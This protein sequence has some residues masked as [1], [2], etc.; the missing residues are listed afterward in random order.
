MPDASRPL[1]RLAL[2]DRV[3][4]AALGDLVF[5]RESKRRWLRDLL[6]RLRRGSRVFLDRFLLAQTVTVPGLFLVGL[7]M[8][9]YF[10]FWSWFCGLLRPSPCAPR[11]NAA[12][13][14]GLEMR[15]ATARSCE[16][17]T[18][19]YRSKSACQPIALAA[20]DQQSAP[21]FSSRGG[22]GGAGISAEHH[23]FRMGLEH[24][25]ERFARAGP[26]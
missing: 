24:P 23:L 21:R 6:A 8:A 11:C 20:L 26:P 1:T 16:A 7:Y 10:A 12:L 14:P 5:W 25:G 18:A 17:A 9:I 4:S 22:L 3:D 19:P 13:S 15:L 2:L